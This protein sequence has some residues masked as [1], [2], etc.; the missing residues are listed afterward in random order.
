MAVATKTQNVLVAKSSPAF[1][2]SLNLIRKS[3]LRGGESIGPGNASLAKDIGS[4]TKYSNIFLF[5]QTKF[6]QF[7]TKIIEPTKQGR[8]SHWIVEHFLQALFVF[9]MHFPLF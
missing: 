6:S 3:F 5:P 7:F 8:I 9:C 4:I 2:V 1:E